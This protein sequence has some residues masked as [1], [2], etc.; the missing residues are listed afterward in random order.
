MTDKYKIVEILHYT[1]K[2]GTGDEFHH[3]MREVSVPLHR[4]HGIDVVLFAN[5]IHNPD[6]YCLIRAFA[7]E[8]SMASALDTFYS[9]SD[10]RTGPRAEIIRRIDSSMKCVLTLSP[11]A[12][13]S[14]R[15]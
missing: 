1:L 3:I 12:V 8:D 15:G 13:E 7:S 2:K 14:L 11:G 9:G 4:R 10:W 6:C 5:S